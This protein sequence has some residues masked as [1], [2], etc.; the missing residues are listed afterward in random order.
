MKADVGVLEIELW[1]YWEYLVNVF[2][3]MWRQVSWGIRVK[4][5]DF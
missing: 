3:I 4:I 2:P 5:S 1:R